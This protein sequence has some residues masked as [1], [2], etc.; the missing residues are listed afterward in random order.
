MGLMWDCRAGMAKADSIHLLQKI[1]ERQEWQ[2]GSATC[3]PLKTCGRN[4]VLSTGRF[5][6]VFPMALQILATPCP[7]APRKTYCS[8]R[9]KASSGYARY[10]VLT[11]PC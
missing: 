3:L 2:C 10:C 8:S 9:R 4:L 5:H 7:A 1:R 11:M 6:E